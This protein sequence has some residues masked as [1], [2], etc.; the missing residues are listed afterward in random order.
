MLAERV[1]RVAEAEK[2]GA[3]QNAV[4]LRH[5]AP[6]V[7]SCGIRNPLPEPRHSTVEI[8]HTGAKA[9]L[10]ELARHV[11]KAVV[12]RVVKPAHPRNPIEPEPDMR[13]FQ[14]VLAGTGQDGGIRVGDEGIQGQPA[15][16]GPVRLQEKA[17]RRLAL[18]HYVHL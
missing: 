16:D 10:E 7:A 8:G 4:Q 17:H 14:H 2:P 11:L 9:E 15:D 1:V 12:A 13:C 18:R 5:H 3:A 6:L